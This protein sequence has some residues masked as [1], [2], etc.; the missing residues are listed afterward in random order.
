M[1]GATD[2]V[3]ENDTIYA[4]WEATE[5]T[6]TYNLDGGENNASNPATYDIETAT[7]TFGAATKDGETFDS[8][9]DKETLDSAITE[10][11]LGSTG[12]VEVWVKW[13]A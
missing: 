5:Y 11:A 6:I 1:V 13:A 9:H 4:I 2:N 12:N 8:W 3:T 7:I 10:I